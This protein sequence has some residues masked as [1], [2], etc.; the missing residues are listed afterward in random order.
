MREVE[1]RTES[2]QMSGRKYYYYNN[3]DKLNLKFTLNEVK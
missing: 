1:P 3:N 2:E